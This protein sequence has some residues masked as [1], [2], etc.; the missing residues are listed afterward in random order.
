VEAVFNALRAD[1]EALFM[2]APSVSLD[3]VDQGLRD[4]QAFA[5]EQVCLFTSLSAQPVLASGSRAGILEWDSR[6]GRVTGMIICLPC[7]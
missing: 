5:D 7:V 3:A 4:M 1:V 6:P 2:T